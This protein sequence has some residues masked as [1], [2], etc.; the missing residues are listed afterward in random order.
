MNAERRIMIY[1]DDDGQGQ[2]ASYF[3]FLNCVIS[4]F[5]LALKAQK[6]SVKIGSICGFG[7]SSVSKFH[8]RII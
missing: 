8:I 7:T 6:E 3:L 5:Q 4:S 1:A 2:N